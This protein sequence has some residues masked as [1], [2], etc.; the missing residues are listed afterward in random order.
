MNRTTA[1]IRHVGASLVIALSLAGMATSTGCSKCTDCDK[2]V[3]AGWDRT[4]PWE[5]NDALPVCV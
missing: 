4:T 3:W 2:A 5:D 1:W